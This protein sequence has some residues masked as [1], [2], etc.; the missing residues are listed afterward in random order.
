[1]GQDGKDTEKTSTPSFSSR[2][3][4][5]WNKPCDPPLP[6]PGLL[7]A[8]APIPVPK[9]LYPQATLGQG[10]WQRKLGVPWR[11]GPGL[12]LLLLFPGQPG[13]GG[14]VD[15][16]SLPHP[17]IFTSLKSWVPPRAGE[18]GLKRRSASFPEFKEGAGTSCLI[19]LPLRSLFPFCKW[20]PTEKRD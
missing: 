5:W 2:P 14:H 18:R 4:S 8:G 13:E 16:P 7:F 20:I 6:Q 11:A 15:P 10:E 1:M 12:L 3:S 19:K 9:S 17:H